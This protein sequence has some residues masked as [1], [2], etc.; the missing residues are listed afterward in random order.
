MNLNYITPPPPPQL[1]PPAYLQ[2]QAAQQK[3]SIDTCLDAQ[4][5]RTLAEGVLDI[6]ESEDRFF[7]LTKPDGEAILPLPSHL[8]Q[9]YVLKWANP[10]RIGGGAG[11]AY[12]LDVISDDSARART[13]H[14]YIT[15][16]DEAGPSRCRVALAKAI[17]QLG[18]IL[19]T[20]E[21]DARDSPTVYDLR[22]GNA[23]L[24]IPERL[25]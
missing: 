3:D 8:T 4:S 9:I 12:S 16:M 13:R 25:D 11:A 19:Y 15:Y 18:P 6:P 20:A 14:L 22:H 23:E 5:L 1:R 7:T 21:E 10:T 17:Q 24:M 2:A